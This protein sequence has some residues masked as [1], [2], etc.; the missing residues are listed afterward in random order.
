MR[1]LQ[2]CSKL[3]RRLRGLT[4][5]RAFRESGRGAPMPLEVSE[6]IEAFRMDEVHHQGPEYKEYQA[7]QDFI[8]PLFEALGWDVRNTARLPAVDRE[9]IHEPSLVV[10]G[11]K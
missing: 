1:T 10:S 6:L 4:S 11:L 3:I 8:D 2:P 7:R 9:V 5:S